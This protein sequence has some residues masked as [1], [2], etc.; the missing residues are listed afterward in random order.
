M[1]STNVDRLRL[2]VLLNSLKQ[3]IAHAQSSNGY[4]FV[5]IIYYKSC[6]ILKKAV[7]QVKKCQD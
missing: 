3:S 5:S 4:T 2:R 7:I 6:T 1:A